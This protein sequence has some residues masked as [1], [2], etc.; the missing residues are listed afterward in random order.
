MLEIDK[1]KG[2]TINIE[3]M[4][5]ELELKYTNL[6]KQ[7]EWSA[8]TPASKINSKYIVM[9]TKNVEPDNS[10]DKNALLKILWASLQQKLSYGTR[11]NWIP[12]LAIP[13]LKDGKPKTRFEKNKQI[14]YCDFCKK[15][16]ANKTQ[17]TEGCEK[18][19]VS[20]GKAML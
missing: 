5:I 16:S 14:F 20:E 10:L 3:L 4:L 12:L 15:W 19:K 18:R 9:T 11:G 7:N 2:S 13:V 17:T 8:S 1:I 6:L